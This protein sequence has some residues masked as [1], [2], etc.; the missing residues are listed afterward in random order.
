MSE[1]AK[2]QYTGDS[3]PENSVCIILAAGSSKR[4]GRAKQLMDAGGMPLVMRSVQTALSRFSRAVVV[5]GAVDLRAA[6][7]P[8]MRRIILVDNPIWADGQMGSLQTGLRA[9]EQAQRYM[10]VLAD[11]PFIRARTLDRLLEL[12][13]SVPAAYPVHRG[14]RGHPVLFGR[15]AARLIL[16]GGP[17]ERAMKII[18]P[19]HP[20]E[21]EVDD[22][23]IYRDID[24]LED[25]HK[26]FGGEVPWPGN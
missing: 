6:L 4:M 22:P 21:V 3:R 15:E 26:N 17:E 1:S 5:Q 20:A 12:D 11:L 10:V 13:I 16:E 18:M 24:T 8:V 2:D 9:A 7:E 25:Y 19:L 14:R 23:G